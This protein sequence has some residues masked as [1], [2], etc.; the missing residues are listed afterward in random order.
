MSQNSEQ[1]GDQP[2]PLVLTDPNIA[3]MGS[4][5]PIWSGAQPLQTSENARPLPVRSKTIQFAPS[6]GRPDAGCTI[7]L[8]AEPKPQRPGP[9]RRTSI[10]FAPSSNERPGIPSR[11]SIQFQRRVTV[12]QDSEGPTKVVRRNISPP[13]PS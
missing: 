11:T 1:S 9:Q 10:Q 6:S 5:I 12:Q 8:A 2:T 4:K 7:S 3:I 13:A